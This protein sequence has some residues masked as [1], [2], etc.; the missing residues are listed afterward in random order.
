VWPLM[1]DA[2]LIIIGVPFAAVF[3]GLLFEVL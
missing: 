3:L 1:L 2:A